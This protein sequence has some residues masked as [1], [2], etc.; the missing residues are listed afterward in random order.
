MVIKKL[1]KYVGCVENAEKLIKLMFTK[2][3]SDNF[4]L[5]VSEALIKKVL[6]ESFKQK[7]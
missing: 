1:R 2:G 6:H 5:P 7:F 4:C 3:R